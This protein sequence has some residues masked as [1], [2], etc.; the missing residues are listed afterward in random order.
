MKKKFLIPVITLGLV[1]LAGT[2]YFSIARAATSDKTEK[3]TEMAQELATKLG[4]EQSKVQTA[5]D[6][7]RAT[8]QAERRVEMEANLTKAVTDGVITAEQKQLFLNK[9]AENQAE[10]GKNR[11]EMKTWAE[12]NGIDMTKLQDYGFGKG[13]G[14]GEGSR[15]NC[16][17]N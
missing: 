9:M 2:T 1:A 17:N 16:F 5:M 13:P 12:A 15:G 10:P 7:I 3:R 11:G 4:L 8:H 14:R 6:E